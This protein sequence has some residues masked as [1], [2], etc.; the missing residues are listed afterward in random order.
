MTTANFSNNTRTRRPH[1]FPLNGNSIH[2]EVDEV[3]RIASVLASRVD[4]LAQSVASA[5]RAE[6]DFY[7]RTRVVTDDELLTSS[8]DNL[9]FAFKGLEA[10]GGS[11]R[12]RSRRVP[13][14][15]PQVS[16]CQR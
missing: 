12:P 1:R 4:E 6:V 5:V 13:S 9:Q 15:P 7:K 10:A 16:H 2:A 8:T 11:L 14:A 3:R